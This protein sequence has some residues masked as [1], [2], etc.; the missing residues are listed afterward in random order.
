MNLIDY[1]MASQEKDN[2]IQ[3]TGKLISEQKFGEAINYLQQIMDT[4]GENTKALA[5]MEQIK[6][7][8]EYQNRDYF[9]STNLDMDPWLE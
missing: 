1:P 9:G 2:F 8:V 3:I 4:D 5:L 6:K 7:I